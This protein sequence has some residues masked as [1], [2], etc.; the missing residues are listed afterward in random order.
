M[1][2]AEIKSNFHRNLNGL[3]TASEVET[4]FVIFVEEFLK[5]NRVQ[6][7]NWNEPLNDAVIL[8]F[9]NALSALKTGKPYQQIIGKAQFF[10]EVFKVNEHTLIPRPETEELLEMAIREIKKLK[11]KNIQILDIGTGSGVIPII[12]K[13]Y[14]PSAEITS[15]DICP[16]AIAIAKEN[17]Q[18]HQSEI[19]FTQEDY[20]HTTLSKKYDIIISNPPYI[21]KDENNEIEDTVK[22]FEPN[23][24]LFSPTEDPLIFYRKI[25][26]DAKNHLINGGMIFLEINQKLGQETLALYHHFSSAQL[27]KDL[28]GN[29]RILFITK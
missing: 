19:H 9:Q 6:L 14:F 21:G 15:M 11:N 3:Y 4:L 16:E 20:L 12:L 8:K 1:V 27:I 18:T 22:K 5:I 2:I 25:A 26:I 28:S 13:K 10:G 24:A 7:R 17:A 23:I 29:D